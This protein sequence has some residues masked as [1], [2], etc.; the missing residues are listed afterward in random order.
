VTTLTGSK[1]RAQAAATGA[2]VV[3][4]TGAADFDGTDIDA[5]FPA[6]RETV[7]GPDQ[8]NFDIK[9]MFSD[10]IPAQHAALQELLADSDTSLVYDLYFLGAWPVLLGAPGIRPRRSVAVGISILALLGDTT[11]LMG[12][13]PGLDGEAARAAHRETNAQLRGAFVSSQEYLAAVLAG[14]GARQEIPFLLDGVFTVPDWFAQLTVKEFEFA[15]DDAPPKVRFA[16]PVPTAPQPDYVRPSW[17]EELDHRPVVVVTQGTLATEDPGLL[18]R[19]TLEALAGEDVLVIATTGRDG[20]RLGSV[21]PANARVEEF[22]PFDLL[23]PHADVLVTNGGYGGVQKAL[24][25]GVPLVVGGA[26]EDKPFVA[27]RVAAFGAGLDLGP[28]PSAQDIRTAVGKV[29]A[30][31]SF[32]TAAM[33]IGAAIEKSDAIGT[34]DEL[35]TGS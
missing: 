1:F 20:G 26:T 13:I 7:P 4:L 35:I 18:I 27:A 8:L 25:S 16:G 15:A 11:T 21:V 30:D 2:R 29:R 5:A 3:D 28:A 32:K 31:P 23:L 17:W 19:P 14:V 34:I 24:A 12:P 33:R 22:V 10:F 6:R 9:H